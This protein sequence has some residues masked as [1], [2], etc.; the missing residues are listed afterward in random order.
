MA[1]INFGKHQFRSV[2]RGHAADPKAG[3]KSLVVSALVGCFTAALTFVAPEVAAE[4]YEAN[5]ELASGLSNGQATASQ[6]TSVIGGNA[7][8][9][10]SGL[11]RVNLTSGDGNVQQNA[12]ALAYSNGIS[13]AVVE[14]VQS[15]EVISTNGLQILNTS[16]EDFAFG[17]A[18]GI[19]QV[20][21]SSGTGN[22]QFNGAAIAIGELGGFA[23]VEL[24]DEQMMDEA[25]P[26][27]VGQSS[28]DD[29]TVISSVGLSPDAFKNATGIIQ[30]NQTAGNNNVSSNSFTMSVSP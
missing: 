7:V 29:S 19:V 8:T 9:E 16:I 21:N 23:I 20:N 25:G 11:V 12:A 5:A 14:G 6:N 24:N 22:A 26:T 13:A 27:S 30:V 15:T 3:E 28:S 10:V 18:L 4:D 2:S 1:L 17:G